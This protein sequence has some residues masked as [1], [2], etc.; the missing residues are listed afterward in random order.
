MTHV[1]NWIEVMAGDRSTEA[2]F[3]SRRMAPPHDRYGP[4]SL[5]AWA[6][7]RAIDLDY[8]DNCW[9]RVEV[10]ADQLRAFLSDLYPPDD[11]YLLEVSRRLTGDRRYVIVAEE[12]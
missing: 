12:F 2:G 6:R 3:V 7:E 1:S 10:S 9:L 5:A 4:Y 11:P 8:V